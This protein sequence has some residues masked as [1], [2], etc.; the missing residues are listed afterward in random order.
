MKIVKTFKN[1]SGKDLLALI[2][3]D[4]STVDVAGEMTML[5]PCTLPFCN[6]GEIS[7]ADVAT[8]VSVNTRFMDRSILVK[9]N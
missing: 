7:S 5:V 8:H 9:I 4:G 3:N 2:T 1:L 6:C